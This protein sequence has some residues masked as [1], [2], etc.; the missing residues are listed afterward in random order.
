METSMK[1]ESELPVAKNPKRVAAGRVNG[2]K[3][4]PWSA[5]ER[6][7]QRERAL[8]GQPWQFSTG[9]NTPEGR[10]KAALNGLRNPRR[11]GSLRR[12][13][14][15]VAQALG[16]AGQMAAFRASLGL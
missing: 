2:K 7:R 5:E 8:A 16:L 6:Q 3:R 1:P 9:P 4:R 15:D 14:M 12:A 13:K 10:H 11:P